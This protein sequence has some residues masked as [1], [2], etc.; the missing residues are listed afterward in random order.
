MGRPL[1]F[2]TEE[3]LTEKINEYLN[4]CPDTKTVYFKLKDDVIEKE[5][6]CP[7]ITGLALFL[8]FCDRSSFYD[9]EKRSVFKKALEKARKKIKPLSNKKKYDY[10]KGCSPK[11]RL[12]F[13][14]KKDPRF[15]LKFNFASRLRGALKT[16]KKGTTFQWLDY[17]LDDLIKHLEERFREG[18]NW[19]NY[20]EWHIDHIEPIINF[21]F[22]NITDDAFKECWSLNNLQPLW[23]KENFK[24]G[25]R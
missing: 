14:L 7:T 25:V 16:K 22:N 19:D 9:Y 5:V 13:R 15:R 2:Q 12:I 24:K 23:A 18:M 4:N 3:E 21:K 10:P 11:E 6:P 17:S 1:K 8:G 20:G